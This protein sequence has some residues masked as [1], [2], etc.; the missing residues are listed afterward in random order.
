MQKT[1]ICTSCIQQLKDLA[2]LVIRCKQLL[3]IKRRKDVQWFFNNEF[4]PCKVLDICG[5]FGMWGAYFQKSNGSLFEYVCLDID[6]DKIKFGKKYF[7]LL[8]LENASFISHDIKQRFPFENNTF[9]Q[10]WLFNWYEPRGID[11]K[12][13]FSEINRMLTDDGIFLFHLPYKGHVWNEINTSETELKELLQS[14]AF[15]LLDRHV[16]RQW[17]AKYEFYFW[18]VK[19]LKV[20]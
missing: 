17:A 8:G 15:R 5:A 1:H 12:E 7:K 3:E 18:G 6:E 19:A 13:L 20:G 9:D 10:V 11:R 14:T 2:L 16:F 4:K